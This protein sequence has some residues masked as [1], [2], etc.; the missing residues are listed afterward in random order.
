M[1]LRLQALYEDRIKTIMENKK[2]KS[3]LLTPTTKYGRK[4]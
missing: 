4:K 2:R 1:T 3:G